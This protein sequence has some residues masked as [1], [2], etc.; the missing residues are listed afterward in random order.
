MEIEENKNFITN[1]NFKLKETIIEMKCCF[2]IND[3]FDVYNSPNDNNELYLVSPGENSSIFITRF[4]DKKLIKK[5]EGIKAQIH[6]LKHFYNKNDNTDYLITSFKGS[7]VRLWNLLNYNLIYSLKINYSENT[8]IYSCLSYFP[9]N[10]DNYLIT[11]SNE[12]KEE[13]FT[14]IY[15]FYTSNFL[16]NLDHTNRKDIF[17]LLLWNK[18]NNDY[19]IGTSN[20]LIFI[21]NIETKKIY[22]ILESQEVLSNFNSACLIQ[23]DD[24]DYL[25]VSTVRG[26]II[27]WNLD[28]FIIKDKICYKS[29]YFCNILKWSENYLL[30]AEKNDGCIL[31]I[32]IQRNRVISVL[33]NIHNFFAMCLKK[34]IHPIY[35]ESLL[36]CDI[37]NKINLSIHP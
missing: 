10:K 20:S 8:R 3:I 28:K 15:D 29:S 5:L 35:G 26:C 24:I 32:D 21:N 31:V 12:D 2:G 34:I 30:V 7:T 1:P 14:K 36:S 25:Y 9:K 18:N 17:Y 19:V 22:K 16:G 6:F 23:K 13:D 27:V 4:R 11:S 33:K 37:D